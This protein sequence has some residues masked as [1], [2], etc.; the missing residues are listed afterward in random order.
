M[1]RLWFN[2]DYEMQGRCWRVH[3]KIIYQDTFFGRNLFEGV[4][5]SEVLALLGKNK[6][7]GLLG[8]S[9]SV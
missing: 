5:P 7:Y 3:G 9:V 1:Y 4:E 8:I 2:H 6:T